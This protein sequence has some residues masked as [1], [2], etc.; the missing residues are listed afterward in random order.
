MWKDTNFRIG[1]ISAIFTFS[2]LFVLPRIPIVVSN[3]ILRVDS[4]IG[5]YEIRLPGGDTLDF[6]DFKKSIDFGGGNR[7]VY[8]IEESMGENVKKV[9]EERLKASGYEDFRIGIAEQEPDKLLIEVPKH[10]N[11]DDIEYL[12]Q[13]TGGLVIKELIDPD[14]WDPE[15]FSRYFSTPELWKDTDIS[16]KDVE[17]IAVLSPRPDLVQLQFIFNEEGKEKFRK[18]VEE[19]VGKPV[20]LHLDG[21]RYPAAIPIISDDLLNDPNINPVITGPFNKKEMEAFAVKVKLPKLELFPQYLGIGEVLSIYGDNFMRNVLLSLV[22]GF[23]ISCAYLVFK[24][25]HFGVLFSGVFLFGALL[26]LSLHKLF[27]VVLNLH[28]LLGIVFSLGLFIYGLVLL[29][30]KINEGIKNK[31]PM[32]ICVVEAYKNSFKSIRLVGFSIFILFTPSFF[33]SKSDIRWFLASISLGSL[34]F[35][36]NHVLIISTLFEVLNFVRKKK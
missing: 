2:I 5:G 11:V 27:F 26:L 23:G 15:D 1:L 10:Q 12:T 33:V 20:A 17:N 31:K 28:S 4:Y 22:I 13:G 6:T 7:L 32:D 25:K 19:S 18:L 34:V 16:E 35:I 36:M 8:Q 3:S 21:S 9:F 30:E 14:S 24:Y 29:G